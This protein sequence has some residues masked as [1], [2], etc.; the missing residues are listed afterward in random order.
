MVSDTL[1][2]LYQISFHYANAGQQPQR[3]RCYIEYAKISVYMSI[4]PT[5][6]QI[7]L[8]N[9]PLKDFLSLFQKLFQAPFKSKTV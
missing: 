4:C 5:F 3:G 7:F 9:L 1:I 2:L 8:R 6:H